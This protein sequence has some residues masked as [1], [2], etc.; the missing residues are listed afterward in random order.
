MTV[1]KVCEHE[2]Y[3]VVARRQATQEILVAKPFGNRQQAESTLSS[4]DAIDLQNDRIG[5]VDAAIE[6]LPMSKQPQ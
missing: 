1:S 2:Q 3:W 6:A 4:E 5:Q